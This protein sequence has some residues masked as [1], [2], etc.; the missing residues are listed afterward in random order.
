M[1]ANV[2]NRQISVKANFAY[3]AMVL[4]S[5]SW[6]FAIWTK[7]FPTEFVNCARNAI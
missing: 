5:K 6:K 7:Y 1:A 3:L 4:F 2:P